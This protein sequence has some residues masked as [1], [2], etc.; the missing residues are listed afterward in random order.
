M[1]KQRPHSGWFLPS[2]AKQAACT[3]MNPEE[4]LYT[5]LRYQRWM[6]RMLLGM[7]GMV[8]ALHQVTR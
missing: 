2:L 7:A 8:A 5:L 6:D 1:Q 4:G 3:A